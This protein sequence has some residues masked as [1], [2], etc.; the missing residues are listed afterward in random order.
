[1]RNTALNVVLQVSVLTVCT[2]H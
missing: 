1:V 2:G